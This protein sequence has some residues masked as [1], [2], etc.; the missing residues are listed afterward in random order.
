MRIPLLLLSFLLAVSLSAQTFRASILGGVNLSQVDGDDLLGFYQPGVNAGLRVVA[1]L[2]DRWRV[3]PELLYSQQGAHRNRNSINVSD[4]RDIRLN[5][6]ELP[7]MVYY[8]DWRLAAEAGVSYQRLIGYT[9][10][11]AAG[12]DITTSF[13]LKND[14]AAANLGVTLFLTPRLGVNFRWSKQFTDLQQA[15]A[16]R[17]RGRTLS[18]RAVYTLGAGESLPAAPTPPTGN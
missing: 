17:L 13:P 6:V 9:I 18:L 2:G 8:K 11:D 4:F 14:H 15:E 10:T 5:T 16:P 7:L 3:G 12:N 1:L